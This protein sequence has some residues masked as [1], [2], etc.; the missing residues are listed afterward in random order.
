MLTH[1]LATVLLELAYLSTGILLCFMGLRLLEKGVESK[2]KLKGEI[3][4]RKWALLTSSPGI[5]FALC[6]LGIILYAIVTAYR[7][8]Y[9][10]PQW[11]L[12]DLAERPALTSTSL[13]LFD[14]KLSSAFQDCT[15][16]LDS[17][18]LRPL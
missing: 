2:I 5:V 1:T 18:R 15:A 8:G 3:G 16:H 17:P 11:L 13:C 6:G 4:G 10:T 7:A 14:P 12:D 9:A